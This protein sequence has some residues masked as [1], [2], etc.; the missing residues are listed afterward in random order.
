MPGELGLP[1]RSRRGQWRGCVAAL[2]GLS[3]LAAGCGNRDDAGGRAAAQPGEGQSILRVP[4]DGAGAAPRDPNFNSSV[5]T[6]S[7][8]D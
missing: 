4:V 1:R 6:W 7:L 3:L 8:R 5:V 2:C